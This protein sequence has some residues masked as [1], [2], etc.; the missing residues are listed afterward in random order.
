MHDL[1]R[2]VDSRVEMPIA[3]QPPRELLLRG[4]R[5]VTYAPRLSPFSFNGIDPDSPAT[6]VDRAC[7]VGDAVG[8]LDV[9]LTLDESGVEDQVT[10]IDGVVIWMIGAEFRAVWPGWTLAL[11]MPHDTPETRPRTQQA[12][13]EATRAPAPVVDR[14]APRQITARRA[15]LP[16]PLPAVTLPF[17]ISDENSP[18]DRGFRPRITPIGK[19]WLDEVAYVHGLTQA[20]TLYALATAWHV[21]DRR[22]QDVIARYIKRGG[23]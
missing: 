20:Q 3:A 18:V 21:S 6:I 2:S 9:L 12:R 19:S 22:L 10:P 7:S 23:D 15:A 16:P 13:P 4:A 8:F 5:A 1:T 14:A 11:V 17:S